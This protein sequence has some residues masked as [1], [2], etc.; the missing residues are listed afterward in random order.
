M[1]RLLQQVAQR[2]IPGHLHA[3]ESP[4][5]A[6]RGL[7]GL[8]S[9]ATSVSAA[10]ALPEAMLSRQC[11]STGATGR[12]QAGNVSFVFRSSDTAALPACISRNAWRLAAAAP[13]VHAGSLRQYATAEPSLA[14]SIDLDRAPDT[15]AAAPAAW[16]AGSQTAA[17]TA[18][19]QPPWTFTRHLQKRKTLPKRMGNMLQVLEVE[20]VKEQL[21]ARN[22]PDFGPGAV[23]EVKLAI[24]ENRRRVA[25]TRGLCIARRNRGIRTTFTIRNHLGTAGGI[26]RTF[27]L[28]SPHIE[29]IR[30]ITQRKVRRAKLYY[31]RNRQPREYR[32]S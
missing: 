30:V 10:G 27:P 25:V 7:K 22:I 8:L 5:S 31:L 4:T 24:P 16:E 2:S 1:Q 17:A 29:E 12:L 20:K 14:Q 32:I 15:A 28:F 18:P 21:A 11:I 6:C 23:L 19:P 3:A 13:T 26:E 9:L